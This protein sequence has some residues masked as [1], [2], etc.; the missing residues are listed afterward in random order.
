MKKLIV[1]IGISSFALNGCGPS[2]EEALEKQEQYTDSVQQAGKDS[3]ARLSQDSIAKKKVKKD[4]VAKSSPHK[5]HVKAELVELQEKYNEECA[6][7]ESLKKHHKLLRS[8]HKKE[9]QIEQQTE[10]V[11]QLKKQIDWIKKQL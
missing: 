1:L 4:S 8:K 11:E 6:H 3:L 9:A 5:K 10:V 2:K 7:L